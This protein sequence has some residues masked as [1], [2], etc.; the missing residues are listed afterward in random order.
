MTKSINP[1][2]HNLKEC[3]LLL[4]KFSYDLYY[5][6][7]PL[8]NMAKNKCR[9]YLSIKKLTSVAF[10]NTFVFISLYFYSIMKKKK[11]FLVN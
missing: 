1:F 8:M 4:S 6:Q 11:A 5:D 7:K 3:N 9:L 10:L 2:P